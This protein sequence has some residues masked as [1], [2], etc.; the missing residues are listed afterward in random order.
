[1]VL[2]VGMNDAVNEKRF[3]SPNETGQNVTRMLQAALSAHAIPL[4]VTVHDPDVARLMQRH[5]PQTYGDRPPDARIADLN[6]AL[7]RAVARTH[8]QVVDFHEVLK[9]AGGAN[10]AL[11]TDG[12]HL[13]R[14]GYRLLAQAVAVKLPSSARTGKI[15]CVGDSLTYGTGVRA[16]GAPDADSDS[17]PQQLKALLDAEP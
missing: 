11:S 15:L 3:L 8:T 1:M 2:F 16:A 10:L 5:S 17:Y 4:L 7:L 9:H 13:T 6:R 12:V 14:A